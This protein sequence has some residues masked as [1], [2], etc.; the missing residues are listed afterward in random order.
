[1]AVVGRYFEHER[2]LLGGERYERCTFLA[3]VLVFDG[4]PV[5]LLDNSFEEC[6]WAF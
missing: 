6:S 2:V 4:R 3:C 1:M 5:E